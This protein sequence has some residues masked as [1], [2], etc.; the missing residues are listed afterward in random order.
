MNKD[1]RSCLMHRL[2]Y[3]EKLRVLAGHTTQDQYDA[4]ETIQAACRYW[5]QV[6]GEAARQVSPALQEAHS[7]IPWRPMIGIRNESCMIIWALTMKPSGKP[8]RIV[9][10]N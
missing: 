9:F 2:D 8:F 4:D 3:A 10:P 6:I 7:S 5:L 1:D